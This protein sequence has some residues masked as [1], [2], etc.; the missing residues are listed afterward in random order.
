MFER[1]WHQQNLLQKVFMEA[2]CDFWALASE[3]LRL[4]LSNSLSCS[5]VTAKKKKKWYK[6]KHQELE[7]AR[8][9]KYVNKYKTYF[10]HV[11]N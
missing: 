3:I 4:L 2:V 6:M 10:S 8:N 1:I 5:P 9:G 7:G 11:K